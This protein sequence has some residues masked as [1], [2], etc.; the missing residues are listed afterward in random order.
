[1]EKNKRIWGTLD[2]FF[3]GGPILGRIVANKGFLNNLLKADPFDEYHFFLPNKQATTGLT[4]HL[5]RVAPDMLAAGRILLMGRGDLAPRLATEDYHCFHLSDCI[6]SQPYLARLRNRL[7][8]RIFP[9]TGPIHSLSYA[10][11]PK[12][13]LQHLWPGATARDAIVCTSEAGRLTVQAYFDLLRQGFNLT[14]ASHPG[15]RLAR[16]PL[17]V[18]TKVY[19][20]AEDKPDGPIR[21]LVFGRISH[22]SKM[23]LVPLVR[24]LHRLVQDGLDPASIELVLAGWGDK[25]NHLLNILT[26]LTGNAGI[27]M[28]VLMRPSESRK[29]QL[30]RDASL[31]VSIADNPQETFGITLLEAAAFGLPVV[32]SDYDGYRDIVVH[33]ETGLLIPTTG[34]AATPDTDL[35]APLTFDNHYHLGLAQTTAVDIPALAAGLKRLLESPELRATMGAAARKRVETSFSWPGIVDRHIK[36]WDELWNEPVEA[37]PLR[38]IPHPLAPDFGRLFGHYTSRVLRDDLMLECGRLGEAFYREKDFPNIYAGLKGTIDPEVARKLAFF[39]RK[40]VDSATLIRK[41]SDFA[42][43]M[44]VTEIENHILWA[45]KQD[46]LQIKE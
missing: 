2:P 22:H 46:I 17:G 15:P 42:P 45:L 10:S 44:N 40:P 18:N 20:P 34:P 19:A 29:R 37:G 30:F 1:M 21:I 32:A 33:D 23:D 24:A 12:A 43:Q 6:T 9:I 13:F 4:K 8:E 3:E 28:S 14:E 31:F 11:Y 36:L 38:D 35:T 39:G 41:V 5:E 25:D 27:P 16:I 7:S 26:N